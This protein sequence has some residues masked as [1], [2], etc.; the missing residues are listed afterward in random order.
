MAFLDLSR[1][2]ISA[3]DPFL[4]PETGCDWNLIVPVVLALEL[5]RA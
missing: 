2:T 5:T 4:I 3:D 1:E